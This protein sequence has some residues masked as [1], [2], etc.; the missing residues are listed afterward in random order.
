MA[1]DSLSRGSIGLMIFASV[2][3][4]VAPIIGMGLFYLTALYI[5]YWSRLIHL[6]RAT[7]LTNSA[8]VYTI[9]LHLFHEMTRN[10]S[11]KINNL[12]QEAL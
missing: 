3:L 7:L 5:L 8:C 2:V 4:T 11:R 12:K 1:E 10:S 6:L 9:M